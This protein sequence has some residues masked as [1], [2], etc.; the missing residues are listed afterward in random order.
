MM[1]TYSGLN[2]KVIWSFIPAQA[3]RCNEIHSCVKVTL[4]NGFCLTIS[5]GACWAN[6]HPGQQVN[7]CKKTSASNRHFFLEDWTNSF[8]NVEMSRMLNLQKWKVKLLPPIGRVPHQLDEAHPAHIVW[9]SWAQ[10]YKEEFRWAQVF[11]DL[12][13]A[14]VGKRRWAKVILRAEI[15]RFHPY[16]LA[17]LKI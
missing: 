17:N 8:E 10:V 5:N 6:L 2:V 13:W 9:L 4:S 15:I 11:Q 3:L 7:I 14:H 12:G 16:S 1:Q